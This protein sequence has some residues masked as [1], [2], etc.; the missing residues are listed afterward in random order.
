VAHSGANTSNAEAKLILVCQPSG[1]EKFFEEM[2][3]EMAKLSSAA[4][5]QK[6]KDVMAKYGVELLGPP[7]F[8]PLRPE[9]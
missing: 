2:G 1:F 6:M 5:H 3:N 4:A 8:K 9:Y 7:L